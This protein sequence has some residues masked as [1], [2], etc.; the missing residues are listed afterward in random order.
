M[1]LFR[2]SGLVLKWLVRKP[3]THR[4]PFE[5]RQPFPGSRGAVCIEL[6]ACVFCG[7][8]AKRC[9]TQALEVDRA[10]KRWIV[11][12]LRCISCDYCVEHCPKKCLALSTAH[13]IPTVTRDREVFEAPR[14]AAPQG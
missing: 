13:G 9:P 3:C 8:C 4:Y 7:I 5:P 12:R 2:M 1:S 11:D 6:P 10:A 14:A